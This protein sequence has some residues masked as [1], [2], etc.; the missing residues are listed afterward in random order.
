[1][2]LYLQRHAEAESGEPLDPT[3]QLT[4]TGRAQIRTM[5]EFLV[6]QIG[7]VDLVISSPFVRALETARGMASALGCDVI[8]TSPALDPDGKSSVAWS[9]IDI[10]TR[11]YCPEPDTAHVL[12]VSHHP[13]IS[14]LAQMLCGVKTDEG[15]FHH[16][17]VMH[18]HPGVGMEYFVPP[19]VVERDEAEVIEA[20]AEV[21]EALIED[22]EQVGRESLKHP[23]HAEALQPIRAV[24]AHALGRFFRAQKRAL[25]KSIKPKLREMRE[26]R[27]A[28]MRE[29][30]DDAKDKAAQII[31]D[32][33][34]ISI[35]RGIGFDYAG[36]LQSA[37]A[38]GYDSGVTDYAGDS[39]I[40]EDVVQAYLSDHS[41]TKLTGNFDATSVGRLRNAL[42]DAYQSGADYDGLVKAVQDEYAGFSSV[43]AGMIAQT[44]MNNAYNAGRKQLGLDMGFNE[45][46]W[47]PE[48]AA[49][50]EI[51][52]P[53]V[54]QGWIP[55]DEDFGSGDDAPAAHPN[56]DC[57]LDVRYNPATA[58]D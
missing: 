6:H 4:S 40:A 47:N 13:L 41:L 54:L 53:N 36:A 48:V 44:E 8:E 21:L 32:Q 28:G 43:R 22:E 42:A 55:I 23:K 3:R 30:D 15:K 37:L 2:R 27:I 52:M 17:A 46:L 31:P 5:G 11:L 39:E 1:M 18:I 45:K 24:A 14:D 34:P 25:L 16:A 49:C 56:C 7:R 50:I 58:E 26:S 51:C 29:A 19:K 57:S 12:V 20:A 10:L 35:T 9:D 33:L 38:A